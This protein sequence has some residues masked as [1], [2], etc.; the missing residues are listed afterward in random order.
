M[1]QAS[2]YWN[3]TSCFLTDQKIRKLS[4]GYWLGFLIRRNIIFRYLKGGPACWD[5]SI[6]SKQNQLP[7][8]ARKWINC[9]EPRKI[10]NNNHD[11][12][13]PLI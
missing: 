11:F 6:I 3:K 9:I 12:S 10:R 1:P 8:Y 5:V 4:K 7:R 2:E 13:G